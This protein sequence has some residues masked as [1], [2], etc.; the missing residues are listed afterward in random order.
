ML[1]CKNWNNLAENREKWGGF[2]DIV[3]DICI[4]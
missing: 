1:G 3:M 4:A 2:V